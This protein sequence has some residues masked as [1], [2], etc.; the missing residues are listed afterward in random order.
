MVV[1]KTL[2]QSPVALFKSKDITAQDEFIKKYDEYIHNSSIEGIENLLTNTANDFYLNGIKYGYAKAKKD[3]NITA[4]IQSFIPTNATPNFETRSLD[5]LNRIAIAIRFRKTLDWLDGE[6]FD[7]T[8]D[9]K[10]V[11]ITK[12]N[13]NDTNSISRRLEPMGRIVVPAKF[14]KKLGWGQGT[15][16]NIFV[17]GDSIAVIRFTPNCCICSKEKDLNGLFE[18]DSKLICADCLSKAKVVDIE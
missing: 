14:R 12:H 8:M 10:T 6:L 15:H 7:F 11:Y 2:V 18:I 16:L 1:N 13:E 3:F 4:L 9:E 17:I 5:G